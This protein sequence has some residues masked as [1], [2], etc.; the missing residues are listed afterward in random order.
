MKKTVLILMSLCF[1]VASFGGFKA[2]RIKAKKPDQFQA[3]I[4]VSGVTYAADILLEGE[5]QKKYFYREL[6]PSDLIAVRL[7]VFNDSKEEVVLPVDSLRLLSPEGAEYPYV[8]PETAAQSVLGE[9][10]AAEVEE[11]SRIPQVGI[12]TGGPVDPRTDPNDPGY[13]P[14]TD[15]ADPR[16]DPRLD[17]QGP[18]TVGRYPGTFPSG[19]ALGR[20]GV[21]LNPGGSGGFDQKKNERKLAAVDFRDKAHTS[22]PI[23]GSLLRDRFLYFSMPDRPSSREGIVLVLPPSRGIL[24]KVVLKF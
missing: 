16:Y 6:T 4:T 18:G 12:G 2:K 3:R 15:P 5:E 23:V 7:A 8:R 1:A 14:R 9:E 10:E 20:P 24:Q 21:I 17:P 22:D 19:G 13:D 11:A